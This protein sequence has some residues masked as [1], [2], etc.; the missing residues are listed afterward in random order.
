[1]KRSHAIISGVSLIIMALAAGFGYGYVHGSLILPDD[2]ITTTNNLLLSRE[3]FGSGIVSWI[4]I[5]IAD[6]LVSW[7]LYRFFESINR[8]VSFYTAL[9]RVIYS[10]VLAYAIAQLVVAWQMLGQGQVE[11]GEIITL[12]ANFETYWSNG[13]IVF[14]L[15]L[16]GLGYLALRT[17]QVPRWMGWLLYVAGFSYTLIHGMKAIVP[18][19]VNLIQ[20]SEVILGIP[21]ALAELGLAV[22]LIWKGGRP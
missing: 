10:L 12:L 1:M 9:I 5:L 17:L 2:P 14:G 18:S 21:M 22:W 8:K 7:G 3:L 13:L 4:V 19:A 15:H 20:M 11:S 16:I 6:L